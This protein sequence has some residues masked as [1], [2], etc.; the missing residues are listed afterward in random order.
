MIKRK[1][2]GS[3]KGDGNKQTKGHMGS[4]GLVGMVM[5]PVQLG[6]LK[7]QIRFITTYHTIMDGGP[8]LD[9]QLSLPSTPSLSTL[10][11]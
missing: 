9:S 1:I 7:F 5:L 2:K 4:L 10:P 8:E 3:S 6:C 11:V